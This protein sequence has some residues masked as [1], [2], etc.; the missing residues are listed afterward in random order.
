MDAYNTCWAV[1]R[2]DEDVTE[3]LFLCLFPHVVVKTFFNASTIWLNYGLLSVIDD[4]RIKLREG[5]KVRN[6]SV[7]KDWKVFKEHVMP[8]ASWTEHFNTNSILR[9][10]FK[11]WMNLLKN[12][13]M[14]SLWLNYKKK[15]RIIYWKDF[16]MS[17]F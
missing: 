9:L 15:K 10:K 11:S 4:T 13:W 5:I 7:E 17:I 6:K 16:L 2:E 3:R 12:M 8:C 1:R 14:N